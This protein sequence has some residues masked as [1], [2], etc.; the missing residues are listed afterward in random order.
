VGIRRLATCTV[1]AGLAVSPGM[2]QAAGWLSP[3]RLNLAAQADSPSVAMD[4]GGNIVAAWQTV[5]SPN[6]VQGARRL[7]GSNGF[8]SLGNLS[9]SPPAGDTSPVVVT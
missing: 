4:G 1:L 5:A 7:I 6:V 8:T 3:T 2:A 9:E